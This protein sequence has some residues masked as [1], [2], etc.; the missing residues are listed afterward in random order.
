MAFGKMLAEQNQ[1]EG[2]LLLMWNQVLGLRRWLSRATVEG[3]VFGR[4][5]HGVGFRACLNST[6]VEVLWFGMQNHG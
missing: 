2:V 4:L 3:L 5:S 1:A 6:R